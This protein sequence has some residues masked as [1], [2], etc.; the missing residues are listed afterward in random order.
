[1]PAPETGLMIATTSTLA[2]RLVFA[3][4]HRAV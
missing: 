1:M 2:V 4:L 3:A